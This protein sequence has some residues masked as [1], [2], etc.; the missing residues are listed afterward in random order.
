MLMSALFEMEAAIKFV[1]IIM[2]DI[3]VAALMDMNYQ[4]T[5]HHAQVSFD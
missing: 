5:E 1:L 4:V 3:T 2:V